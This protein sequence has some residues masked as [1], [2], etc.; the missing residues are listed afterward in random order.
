MYFCCQGTSI[1]NL[2]IQPRVDGM[3]GN[4]PKL[5]KVPFVRCIIL[6]VEVGRAKINRKIILFI[7]LIKMVSQK[8]KWLLSNFLTLAYTHSAYFNNFISVFKFQVSIKNCILYVI[9]Y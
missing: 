1:Y 9:F 7:N 5:G 6:K 2:K 3:G 4:P 8:G